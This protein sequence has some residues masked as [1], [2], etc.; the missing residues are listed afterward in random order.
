MNV[1]YEELYRALEESVKLQSHYAELLNQYDG[2]ERLIFKD[3]REWLQR[4]RKLD[5]IKNKAI[6]RSKS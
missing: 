4:L 2:G 6:F 1:G 3:E 5:N